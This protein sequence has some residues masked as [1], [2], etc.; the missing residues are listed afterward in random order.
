MQQKKI[1]KIKRQKL[2][3]DLS[4]LSTHK[5]TFPWTQIFYSASENQSCRYTCTTIQACLTRMF[6]AAL[7]MMHKINKSNSVAAI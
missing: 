1:K 6:S 3:V 4:I 7:P 5:H 2:L